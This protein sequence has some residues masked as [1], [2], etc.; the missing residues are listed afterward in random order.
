[1]LTRRDCL[2]YSATG[3]AA[4]ALLPSFAGAQASDMIK[5]AIPKTG[6]EIPIIGLGSSAT[7]SELAM[8]DDLDPLKE[9]FQTMLDAGATVFDT[10]PSY[11]RGSAE[12][13]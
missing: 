2:T 9:V 12:E 6:E 7:F 3:C 8:A 11:G 5:R 13:A 4:A 10:A 1:M